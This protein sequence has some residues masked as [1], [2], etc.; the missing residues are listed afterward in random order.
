MRR[1]LGIGAEFL[2]VHM[3]NLRP[4]KRIDLLLRTIAASRRRD[5]LRLLVVAGSSFTPSERLV[6]ELQLRDVVLVKQNDAEIESYL[7]AADAGLYTSESESFGLSI[8]E[9]MFAGKPV[10][11]FRVG[12]IPEVVGDTGLLCDF[13]DVSGLAAR[14]DE[15]VDSPSEAQRI[16]QLGRQRA[17]AHF[18]AGNVV[19]QYEQLYR[20]LLADRG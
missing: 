2:V 13:G 10:L 14:L 12:G 15:L 9:T 20:D 11:A 1:E 5:R 3:S 16:G 7:A 19:P 6:D 8:L 4:L 18:A 17:L